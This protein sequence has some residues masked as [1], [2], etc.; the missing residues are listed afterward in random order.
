MS[1]L[2]Q[3][4]RQPVREAIASLRDEMDQI[5]IMASGIQ[6]AIDQLAIQLGLE[7]PQEQA[8]MSQMVVMH[9]RKGETDAHA[10]DECDESCIGVRLDPADIV[11]GESVLGQ[12]EEPVPETK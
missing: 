3:D 12:L 9:L 11:E 2:R 7:N 4:K 10:I 8:G 1:I 6:S 5:L